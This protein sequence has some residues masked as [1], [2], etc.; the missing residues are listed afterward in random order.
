MALGVVKWFIPGEGF[1]GSP[2]GLRGGSIRPANRYH[3]HVAP[4]DRDEH[5][6]SLTTADRV[7]FRCA[8]C[9][10]GIVVSGPLPLCPMCRTNDWEPQ[11]IG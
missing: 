11:T 4:N 10:Y 8:G 1:S 5:A 7:E 2:A 9:G 6:V 3:Q